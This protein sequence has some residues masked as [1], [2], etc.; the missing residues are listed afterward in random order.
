MSWESALRER[1]KDDAGVQAAVGSTGGVLSID[2]NERRGPY[3]SVVLDI[4]FADETQHMAGFD[5]FRSARTQFRC[6]AQKRSQAVALRDAVIAAIVPAAT[7]DGTEF[8]RAQNIALNQ[9]T[10]GTDTGTLHHEIVDAVIW[11]D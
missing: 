7:K 11:H 9:T 3:P 5:T 1:L 2:W 10:E 8:L 6:T 4:V